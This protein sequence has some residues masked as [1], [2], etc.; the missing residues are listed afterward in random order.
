M[1]LSG[2]QWLSVALAVLAALS[3]LLVLTTRNVPGTSERLERERNLLAVW[4][5][6][7]IRRIS[8]GAGGTSFRLERTGSGDARGFV[9]VAKEREDADGAAVDR[10][11]SGLG[12]ATPVRRIDETGTL[13]AFRL[14]APR[15]KLGITMG[16]T[17]FELALGKDAPS[18]AG[19]AY[20]SVARDEEPAAL[21]VVP[22][23]AAAL[24]RMTAD[25]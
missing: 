25:D 12:F 2:Q 19:A 22:K 21:F 1:K 3:A 16:N 4:N 14:D 7:E 6:D 17:V 20:V 13:A 15:A 8:F 23:D 5:E 10:L 18:P 9:L 11:I 24:F